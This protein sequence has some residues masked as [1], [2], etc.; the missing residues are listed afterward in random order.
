M[1]IKLKIFNEGTVDSPTAEIIVGSNPPI[2]LPVGAE[3]IVYIHK[4]ASVTVR[5]K[6]SDQKE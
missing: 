2:E 6:D 4:G 5:E 1:T 3:E